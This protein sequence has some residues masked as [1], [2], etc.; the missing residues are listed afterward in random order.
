[1]AI[2][3]SPAEAPPAAA[4]DWDIA[5]WLNAPPG[6]GLASLRGRVVVAAGFQML[7]PGCVSGTIPQLREARAL[8]P[9]REVA[10]AA[11][12]SVFEHHGA[13]SPATLKAFL[14]ENRI[15]FPVGIDRA[16]PDGGAV[17]MTMRVYGFRGTPT[18]LLIDRAGRLRRQTF[19]HVSGMQLGAEVAALLGE[20]A[21]SAPTPIR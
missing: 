3:S 9:E 17:P 20:A 4:P 19:G 12:H 7:C 2:P 21:A 6:F 15:D 5:Q 16:D 18:L 14:H 11:I 1:M 8:F 10:V 13:N